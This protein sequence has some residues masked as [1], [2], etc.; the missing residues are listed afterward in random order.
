[1]GYFKTST[2]L[3]SF[4]HS[5]S[6]LECLDFAHGCQ[7]EWAK[8][9]KPC[10]NKLLC[11]KF[12]QEHEYNLQKHNLHCRDQKIYVLSYAYIEFKVRWLGGPFLDSLMVK[13]RQIFLYNTICLKIYFFVHFS[14]LTVKV[15][16]AQT[17]QIAFISSRL[18]VLEKDKDK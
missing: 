7:T 8:Y 16:V 13:E 2:S 18:L 3:F 1:M 10:I 9:S 12:L 4:T 15:I 11:D 6:S 5:E 17:G 14:S